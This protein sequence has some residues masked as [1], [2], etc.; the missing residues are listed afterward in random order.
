[1]LNNPFAKSGTCM[2]QCCS[3]K[4]YL[5]NIAGIVIDFVATAAIN[6]TGQKQV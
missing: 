5:Y 2:C 6:W 3:S 1:M 4:T